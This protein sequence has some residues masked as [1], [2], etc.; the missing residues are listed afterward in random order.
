MAALTITKISML[1]DATWQQVRFGA[2]ASQG[3]IVYNEENIWRPAKIDGTIV[4]AGRDGLGIVL[5][6]IN[7]AGQYGA[8]VTSGTIVIQSAPADGTTYI[9]GPGVGEISP[10][11]DFN[12]P[13]PP[14]P[15]LYASESFKT[16][17]GVG[18][19]AVGSGGELKIQ[20][21]ASGQKKP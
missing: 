10:N 18:G 14:P 2:S 16:I 1:A 15:P 12:L 8:I 17:V 5:H 4:E 9:L 21:F 19:D 6:A 13:P 20:F 7:V 11:A 3:D